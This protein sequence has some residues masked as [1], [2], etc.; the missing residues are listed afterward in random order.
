MN[1]QTIKL[2]FTSVWKSWSVSFFIHDMPA[3]NFFAKK[4]AIILYIILNL[5]FPYVCL[6]VFQKNEIKTIVYGTEK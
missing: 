1:F 5:L 4:D 2:I 6:G 3:S